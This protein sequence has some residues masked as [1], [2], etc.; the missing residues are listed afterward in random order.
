M[1]GQATQQLSLMLMRHINLR[2]QR[3]RLNHIWDYCEKKMVQ[4]ILV[5]MVG[6]MYGEIELNMRLLLPY[7]FNLVI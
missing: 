2:Y 3:E 5:L 1:H 4:N 6:N 7:V